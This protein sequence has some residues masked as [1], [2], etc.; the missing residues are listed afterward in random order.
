[1]WLETRKIKAHGRRDLIGSYDLAI[2]S[3]TFI[4]AI[5]EQ[6]I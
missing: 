6:F 3:A 1:M 2:I 5:R 4:D